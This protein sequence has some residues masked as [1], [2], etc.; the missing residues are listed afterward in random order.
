MPQVF[1][2]SL[3]IFYW[4]CFSVQINF[5]LRKC[6]CIARKRISNFAQ[7]EKNCSME[8]HK[9]VMCFVSPTNENPRQTQQRSL[10]HP[11]SKTW[12]PWSYKILG[13]TITKD[14]SWKKH[15]CITANKNLF[16]ETF[17]KAFLPLDSN[18]T[19]TKHMFLNL[20]SLSRV[21]NEIRVPLKIEHV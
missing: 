10:H 19:N 14:L 13:I 8:I 12:N 5:S 15:I 6:H 4:W 7:W 20:L 1:N 16:R 21:P 3:K 18:A 11:R 17:Q 2:A 9:S